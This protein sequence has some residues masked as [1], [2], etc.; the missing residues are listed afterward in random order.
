MD[1]A[2]KALEEFGKLLIW[3][4][5]DWHRLDTRVLGHIL[6]SPAISLGVG[7][8]RFTEDWEIFVIDR[9]KLGDAFKGNMIDLGTF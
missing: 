5:E 7:P 8:Q 2:N 9:A 1:E 4:K 3:V 6:R